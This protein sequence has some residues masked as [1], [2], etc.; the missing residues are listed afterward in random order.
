[1]PQMPGTSARGSPDGAI[2]MS[3]VDVPMIFTRVPGLTC[4]PTAP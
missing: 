4:E 3:Q 2:A 1:M